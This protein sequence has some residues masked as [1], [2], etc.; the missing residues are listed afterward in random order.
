VQASLNKKA[1]PRLKKARAE[2]VGGM[3]EVVEHSPSWCGFQTPVLS[4]NKYAK[5]NTGASLN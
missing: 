2:K 1:R 5:G 4:I 3:A